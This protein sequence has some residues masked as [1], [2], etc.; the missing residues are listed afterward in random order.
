MRTRI[1]FRVNIMLKNVRILSYTTFH[2]ITHVVTL[3][4]ANAYCIT[5]C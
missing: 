2:R 5:V 3:I 1:R 4:A